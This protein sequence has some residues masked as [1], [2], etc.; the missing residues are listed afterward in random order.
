MSPEPL[1]RPW[2]GANYSGL[3]VG[4]KLLLIGESMYS[5]T[6][7]EPRS[8]LERLVG[9]QITGKWIG[10]FY[11]RVYHA[12]SGRKRSQSSVDELHEFWHRVALYNYVQFPV[13]G[14]PRDRPT[15]KMWDDSHKYFPGVFESLKPDRAIV[16]GSHLGWRL[17]KAGLIQG[18]A[19]GL[20]S[21]KSAGHECPALFV[22]HPASLG[23][24]AGKCYVD[25]IQPFL[26]C[27]SA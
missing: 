16:F 6:G 5:P 14:S 13:I 4:Q 19:E 20:G 8:L 25:R 2:Q 22:K 3:P 17:W 18:G 26:A 10:R 21:L 11:S 23:F 24:S 7:V 27:T 12:V 1:L 9:E 15:D